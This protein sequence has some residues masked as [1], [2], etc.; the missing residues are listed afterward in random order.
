MVR[1]RLVYPQRQRRTPEQFSW[2]DHRLVRERRLEPCS[3][4][5]WALYL[6]WALTVSS[7]IVRSP[8][9]VRNWS[10][11]MLANQPDPVPRQ[12]VRQIRM[13]HEHPRFS[14]FYLDQATIEHRID[15]LAGQAG[16]VEQPVDVAMLRMNRPR[17][18]SP[19]GVVSRLNSIARRANP[20]AA[21]PAKIEQDQLRSGLGCNPSPDSSGYLLEPDIPVPPP[22][23]P[24]PHHGFYERGG[25]V[26]RS[27]EDGVTGVSRAKPG[28]SGPSAQRRGQV[29][30]RHDPAG[31]GQGAIQ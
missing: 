3:A 26:G 19:G 23:E 27:V 11:P 29:A 10:G 18:S 22:R 20:G 25:E 1:K 15:V 9:V 31:G 5:A 12:H 17:K 6:F 16:L 30:R 13:V 8:I 2:V 14:D 21:V 28:I 4:E 7:R 24:V